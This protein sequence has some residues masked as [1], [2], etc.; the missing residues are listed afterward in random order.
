VVVL[1]SFWRVAAINARGQITDEVLG[2]NIKTSRTLDPATGWI[3]KIVSGVG[4]GA[5]VQNESYLFDLVGN[6]TQRQ[7]NNLGLTENFVYDNVYRLSQSTLQTGNSLA[8]PNLTMCYDNTVAGHCDQNLPGSGN[9][10]SRSDIANGATWTYDPNHQHQVT[11]AGDSSHTYA[12]DANGNATSRQDFNGNIATYTYDT[13]RNLETQRVEAYG[14]TQARTI[15]TRWHP[16]F[17]P[18]RRPCPASTLP[19]G[20]ASWPPPER[21]PPW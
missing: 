2:N 16:T 12:Y 8:T 14:T 7:N 6:V 15:N 11:Q 4:G 18:L 1:P 20:R 21:P 9:I 5:G 3:Q 10:T 19:P 17:P 13:T